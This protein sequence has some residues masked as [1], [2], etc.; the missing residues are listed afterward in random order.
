MRR[1]DI[2]LR[3]YEGGEGLWING[4]WRYGNP[5]IRADANTVAHIIAFELRDKLQI[6]ATYKNK[7]NYELLYTHAK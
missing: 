2:E 3:N 5:Y 7:M 1:F 4:I 6:E